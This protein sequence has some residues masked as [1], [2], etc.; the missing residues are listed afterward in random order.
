MRGGRNERVDK[1]FLAEMVHPGLIHADAKMFLLSSCFYDQALFCAAL[2]DSN[3]DQNKTCSFHR[4]VINQ[5]LI[6]Q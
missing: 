3:R 4:D 6:V 1:D 2:C 5:V